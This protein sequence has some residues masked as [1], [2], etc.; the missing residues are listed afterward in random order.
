MRVIT[1]TQVVD[2]P[3][4][5]NELLE[6]KWLDFHTLAQKLKNIEIN[7]NQKPQSLR[8]KFTN[9]AMLG[10]YNIVQKGIMRFIDVTNP[11]KAKATIELNFVRS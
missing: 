2:V 11:K 4:S 7:T 10:K 1:N 5:E 3:Y 6:G 8:Y 9:G